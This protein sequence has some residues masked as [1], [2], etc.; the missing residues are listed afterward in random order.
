M[1]LSKV[2]DYTVGKYTEEGK[3]IS[4]GKFV[5]TKD[6][7]EELRAKYE[8]HA[9]KRGEPLIATTE[10]K[11]K[12]RKKKS[13]I[14]TPTVNKYA[15]E[16]PGYLTTDLEPDDTVTEE[17][18]N[19]TL[20][21]LEDVGLSV[22]K[23]GSYLPQDNPLIPKKNVFFSHEFGTN[24]LKVLDAIQTVAGVMLI[25]ANE[26][27]I[28][29]YPKE[30]GVYGFAV[31]DEKFDVYYPGLLFDYNGKHFMILI[32]LYDDPQEDVD[33]EQVIDDNNS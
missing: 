29:F 11:K 5:G 4:P 22:Q 25:F 30:Q 24:K 23:I 2:G 16:E 33:S 1:A 27:D 8:D 14:S 10:T 6:Q 15:A 13:K 7:V 18:L 32:R 9:A 28:T 31:D 21:G 26:D 12:G 19:R 20:K 3:K 17:A